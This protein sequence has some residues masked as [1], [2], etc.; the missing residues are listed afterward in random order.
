MNNEDK[1]FDLITKL[2]G[3]M[4]KGFAEVNS[5]FDGISAR[6]DSLEKQ[7]SKT[8][9]IIENEVNPRLAALFDGYKQNADK[10]DRIE[11]EVS[12]HDEIIWK[13]VK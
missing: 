4:Q 13:R 9:L 8:N 10:L 12:R 2:Y 1:I 6:V 5:K 11:A 7:V 3:G